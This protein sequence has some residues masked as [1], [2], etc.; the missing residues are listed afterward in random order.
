MKAI[1]ED[2]HIYAEEVTKLE[3]S[4]V[5]NSMNCDVVYT[6]TDGFWKSMKPQR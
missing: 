2:S 4:L 6:R 3:L 5:R 1:V